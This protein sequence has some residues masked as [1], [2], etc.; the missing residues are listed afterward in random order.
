MHKP[1]IVVADQSRARIFTV[2]SPLGE[3]QDL[4]ALVHPEARLRTQSFG[5]DHPGRSFDSG[6]QGRHAMGT[7]V[8]P[9]EQEAIR[10]AKTV[11]DHVRSACND[12]RCNKLL[13]V[14]GPHFL[15][16][17]REHIGSLNNIDITEV[18]KNLGQQDIRAIRDHLPE[19]L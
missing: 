19:R 4:E 5:S 9:K 17:L 8:E 7:S 11:A 6:G 16:L 14:A 2:D 12:G 3:L 10:F 1:W 18:R 13:L 15:G